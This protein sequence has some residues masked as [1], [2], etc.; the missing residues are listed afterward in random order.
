MGFWF[1]NGNINVMFTPEHPFW[2]KDGW[3]ALAPDSS[4]EPFATE[5][6]SKTLKIG[7]YI[8]EGDEW[9]EVYDIQFASTEEDE[10]VYNITV[11]NTHTYLVD[12]ILVHNK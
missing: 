9:V 12:G 11:E 5:Q 8:F 6:E 10:A 3:K 2:T 7:D 4:Q 1:I